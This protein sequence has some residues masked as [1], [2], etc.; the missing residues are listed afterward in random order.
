MKSLKI[1]FVLLN[2]VFLSISA[3][4][5]QYF[6]LRGFVYNEQNQP[7]EGAYVRIQNT[8]AGTTTDKDGKYEIRLKEGL[9]R[10][11]YSYFGYESQS[12][13]LVIQNED[14]VQNIWLKPNVRDLG[15]VTVSNKKKDLSYEI[16]ERVINQRDSL[17]PD[18]SSLKQKL[19]IKSVEDI[20]YLKK[21]DEKLEDEDP[22]NDP[23]NDSV[24]SMNLYEA[25]I[26]LHSQPPD[27][28]KEEKIAAKK[29]GSQFSLF[30]SSTTDGD[31]DFYQN[32][33]MIRSISDNSFVS[34]L[35]STAFL[36]Y[37]FKLLGSYF[38]DGKKVYRIKVI[39]RKLGNAV[40]KGE[41]EVYDE[42]W[43]LKSLD[44]EF[45]DRALIIYD[46]FRVKQNFEFIDGHYMVTRQE[47]F[48]KL[49]TGD[50]LNIG[51]AIVKHSDFL[52]DSSY[53]KKF[54]GAELGRTA[55]DAYD[56]DS[57][58]WND[59]RPEP[60]TKKEQKYVRYQDSMN[61][62]LNSEEYLDSIDAVYNAI[63]A[64]K[65]LWKGQGFINRDKKSHLFLAPAINL[66]DPVAI[67]G[68][69]IRYFASYYKKFESRQHFQ[70]NPYFSYG[71]KNNDLTGT[72]FMG[73]LYDPL[74]R[75]VVNMRV[76]REFDF[77]NNF[78]TISDIIRRDNFYLRNNFNFSHVIELFNGFYLRSSIGIT[79]RMDMSDFE[80]AALGD[81]LFENN[82]PVI[83]ESNRTT[84]FGVGFNF[85]PKQLYIME[86]KEKI[87]LGSRYP[88]FSAY[89]IQ[90]IP[91][92]LNSTNQYSYLDLSVRQLFNIGI[93]GTS[94]YSI[95]AG[96]FFDTTELQIMDY[97]YQRG[98]DPWFF[99]PAMYTY[100]LIQSTF[101]IFDW[102]F[103]SHYVHQFNGFLTS[104][105]PGLRQ[106]EVKTMGG[107]GFLYVPERKYQYS[108][109]YFGVNRIFKIGRERMRLGLY[110]VVAQ[111]NNFGFRN[112]LK[113]SFEFYDEERNT[114]SF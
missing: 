78:A 96:K 57:S 46:E 37:K 106:L 111:S 100:Q 74:R 104:K 47:F 34:P 71:L 109:L 14:L 61:S 26:I 24:P 83:F 1:T 81:S 11:I 66:I 44:L 55:F 25:E 50:Q 84:E 73:Y 45:P 31:F 60:L 41:L 19:Y 70:V 48:W 63:T 75:G 69:R 65:I 108:E 13:D 97:K 32:L 8:N 43:A 112:G 9:H 20:A 38:E 102:Y 35:S 89:Y 80:F 82:D 67:G 101:P 10:V 62:I 54:F 12:L 42:I 2:L 33:V 16:M 105:I 21:R 52:F 36:S 87:I 49:K 98:G 7:L 59:I 56:K 77:V 17:A 15:S 76:G 64:S 39:P 27:K 95:S 113:I 99:T 30:Y 40:F 103:E 79:D 5:Q 92:L 51:N 29:L 94:E 86:P 114:W 110:Y 85:T 90:A 4:G 91:G 88:T 6:V 23:L 72:L 22:L 18:Y 68:W 28:F 107:G 58:Y 93:F 3:F 53:S